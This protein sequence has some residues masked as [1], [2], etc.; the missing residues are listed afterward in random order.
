MVFMPYE[1]SGVKEDAEKYKKK[2]K[3]TWVDIRNAIMQG[4]KSLDK[5][6]ETGKQRL[7]TGEELN[8]TVKESEASQE[9]FYGT[10]VEKPSSNEYVMPPSPKIDWLKTEVSS[11][12]FDGRTRVFLNG[13]NKRAKE[14]YGKPD[15]EKAL[16]QEIIKDAVKQGTPKEE[17][18][19][20]AN[21][22]ITIAK[23]VFKEHKEQ[24]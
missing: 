6:I 3:H 12:F 21:E 20:N 10:Q 22:Y 18:E 23:K 8:K 5:A 24:E 13:Y 15:A 4:E 17:A 11:V 14:A 9:G 7:K 19:K 2:I 1:K 16:R